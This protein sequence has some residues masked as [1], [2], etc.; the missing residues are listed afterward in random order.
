MKLTPFLEIPWQVP[1]GML[2]ERPIKSIRDYGR[3]FKARGVGVSV[4]T[5]GEY[6]IDTVING[7]PSVSN[8]LGVNLFFDNS[9]TPRIGL[10][11]G[12]TTAVTPPR[13]Q[14]GAHTAS[15]GQTTVPN[16]SSAIYSTSGLKVSA[17]TFIWADYADTVGNAAP[18]PD[19]TADSNIQIKFFVSIPPSRPTL[20]GISV[21][22]CQQ[23]DPAITTTGEYWSANYVV[24]WPVYM[25]D[26]TS[27][28]VNWDRATHSLPI[29]PLDFVYSFSSNG[30]YD[31]VF[32]LEGI[33]AY[34]SVNSDLCANFFF[35]RDLAVPG[36]TARFVRSAPVVRNSA[37]FGL[38]GFWADYVPSNGNLW[39]VSPAGGNISI[40]PASSTWAFS[41]DYVSS[42]FNMPSG[43]ND[44][45]LSVRFNRA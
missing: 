29:N 18:T 45:A 26:A 7:R 1:V 17:S 38:R 5:E 12:K 24:G 6:I 23:S 28:I 13:V 4:D 25:Y 34:W 16:P 40:V 3:T 44:F 37:K 9:P 14:T 8:Y 42:M 31:V 2:Q 21:H 43:T 32:R 22:A 33:D 27:T 19:G 15:F 10:I 39:Y 36:I 41:G 35:D 11:G 20:N 30:N